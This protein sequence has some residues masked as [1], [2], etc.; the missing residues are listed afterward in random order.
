VLRESFPGLSLPRPSHVDTSKQ[1]FVFYRPSYLIYLSRGAGHLAGQLAGQR[2]ILR[3]WGGRPLAPMQQVDGR[4]GRYA[5][6]REG[7][8]VVDDG[9]RLWY[10]PRGAGGWMW[11]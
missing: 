2:L 6:P 3:L 9:W 11:C 4:L 10:L 8:A 7:K 1:M 5:A